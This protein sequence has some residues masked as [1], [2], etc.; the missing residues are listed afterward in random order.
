MTEDGEDFECECGL[1]PHMGMLCCHAL[2]VMEHVGIK[3]IP[4][5]YILKSWTKDARDILPQHLAHLQRD[6]S[7]E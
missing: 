7:C 6:Q 2:K 5:K 4:Q 3:E 1:F